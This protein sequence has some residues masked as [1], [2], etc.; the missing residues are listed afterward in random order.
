M[1]AKKKST[2]DSSS[3]E[4]KKLSSY[5]LSLDSSGMDKVEA[6]AKAHYWDPFEP[7]YSRFAFKSKA[8]AVTVVGYTSGKLVISGKGT[9]EFVQNFIEPEVTGEAKLGYDE[10]LN[11]EWF[12]PH[13]GL[14]EAG[15]GDVFGPVVAATVIADEAAIRA[16][17]K[18]GVKDSKSIV[19][20][21]IMRL[22]AT[23]KKT[24]GAVVKVAYCNM[25]RYNEL[26][27]KPLSNLNK[28]LAWLHARALEGALAEKEAPWG[29]LDQFSKQPLVQK[30]MKKDGYDFDL[31]MRTKAESD[32]V[33]AAASICARAE[34]VRQM[35][36]LSELAGEEL[37]KG[38]S[39]AVKAQAK[40]LVSKHGADFLPK[41]SKMHFR[42]V[43]EV[44]GL[45]V[46][47]KKR[48][49]PR[50]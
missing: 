25:A 46:E 9:E 11:P 36:A 50:S 47:E 24:P 20:S 7:A 35:K 6:Y 40:R 29:L 18:A 38:A 45:P 3:K 4:P 14:D 21:S 19:D 41:I 5:T 32:P 15:K 34:F 22:E 28:L 33:V 30:Q 49:V 26:M 42:T 2:A 10:V 13:A 17:I 44:L 16:W 39:A 8:D 27:G 43:K 37:K 12:E 23:I 1:A 48:W 31:R